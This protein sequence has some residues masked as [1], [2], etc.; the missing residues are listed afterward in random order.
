MKVPSCHDLIAGWI[1]LP[2]HGA[3]ARALAECDN[4]ASMI[5]A[6]QK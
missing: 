2:L 1:L 6:R 4:M 3:S 5:Q